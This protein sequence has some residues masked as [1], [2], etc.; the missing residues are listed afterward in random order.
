MIIKDIWVLTIYKDLEGKDVLRSYHESRQAL[1]E[2]L[3]NFTTDNWDPEIMGC[4]VDS[5]PPTESVDRLFEHMDWSWFLDIKKVDFPDTKS[6]EIILTPGMCEI[7]KE[8]LA[9]MSPLKARRILENHGELD[10][11]DPSAGSKTINTILKQ[12]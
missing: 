9:G 10:E 11:G 1:E 6:E 8:S 5:Y 12:L 2:E 3:I 4:S 7:I